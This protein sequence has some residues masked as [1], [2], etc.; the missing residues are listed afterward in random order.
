MMERHGQLGTQ[1]TVTESI[2]DYFNFLN[3]ERSERLFKLHTLLHLSEAIISPKA[4]TSVQP[5][6]TSIPNR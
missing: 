3:N 1:G 2:L 5:K 6:E 4:L